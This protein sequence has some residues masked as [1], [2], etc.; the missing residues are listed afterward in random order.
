MQ[1]RLPRLRVSDI[2]EFKAELEDWRDSLL[3]ITLLAPGAQ[4]VPKDSP[5]SNASFCIS[6]AQSF[7]QSGIVTG[8]MFDATGEEKLYF[9]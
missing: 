5:F 4:I 9:I 6:T 2:V 7:G 1:K 3:Q 8:V